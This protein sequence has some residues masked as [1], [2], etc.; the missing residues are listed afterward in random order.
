MNNLLQNAQQQPIYQ[1]G[2]SRQHPEIMSS[3]VDS[4][5]IKPNVLVKSKRSGDLIK[6][7]KRPI[8]NEEATTPVDLNGITSRKTAMSGALGFGLFSVGFMCN[9]DS[10]CIDFLNRTNFTQYLA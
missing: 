9:S 2:F 6:E 5:I 1:I 3:E 7:S 8:T 4:P 10:N